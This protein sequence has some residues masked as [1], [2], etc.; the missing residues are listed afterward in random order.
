[1]ENLIIRTKQKPLRKCLEF[2]GTLLIWG[3]FLYFLAENF[4]KIIHPS[5]ISE[6]V[7]YRLKFY[8]FCSCPNVIALIVWAIYN[9]LHF[10]HERR[11][12]AQ[13]I[14]QGELISSFNV[15]PETFNSLQN[16]QRMVVFH[17]EEGVIQKAIPL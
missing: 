10:R 9:H 3:I 8:L 4:G 1:M 15:N 5:L 11:K 17:N 12:T 6:D 16:N 14:Q 13:A 2:T 7:A